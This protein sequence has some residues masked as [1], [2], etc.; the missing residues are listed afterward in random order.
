MAKDTFTREYYEQEFKP[1]LKFPDGRTHAI[2]YNSSQKKI[3]TS[4]K[5]DEYNTDFI[6]GII[7]CMQDD[8]YEIV[9][10]KLSMTDARQPSVL[11]IYK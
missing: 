5:V 2:L 11:I 8:R 3:M 7:C 4:G 9:D 10:L 1:Y 6:D